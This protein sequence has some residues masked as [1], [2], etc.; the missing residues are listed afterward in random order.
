MNMR[1]Y[2]FMSHMCVGM[3][4]LAGLFLSSCSDDNN[5]DITGGLSIASYAPTKVIAGQEV[6]ITGTGLG[7]VTAV[8]FPG[9]VKATELNKVGSGLIS[10]KVPAG[11]D[12]NGGELS[13]EANGESV[14]A[15]V[16]MTVGAPAVTIVAP[17]DTEVKI[18]E[19]IEI[20]GTDLEFISKAI[21]PGADGNPVEVDAVRFRRKSTSLLYIPVPMG[22]AAGPADVTLV[23]CSGKA[24][25]T[26]GFT[27]SDEISGGE[28]SAEEG[29]VIWDKGFDVT[30]WNWFEPACTDFDFGGYAPKV[31][32]Q[33]KFVISDAKDD[34]RFCY[35]RGSNWGAIDLGGEN[36]PNNI[37]L[38]SAT[39]EVIVTMTEEL[40]QD[41]I[42]GSPVMHLSGTNFTLKKIVLLP[43]V[44]WEGE[45][46][47]QPNWA[48]WIYIYAGNEYNLDFGPVTPEVGDT[49]R[50]V[51]ADHDADITVCI[52]LGWSWWA[53]DV[54]GKGTNTVTVAAGNNE[55]N[56][57]LTADG[58]ANVVDEIILGG[59]DW[60]ALRIEILGK[61]I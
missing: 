9:G 3:A 43:M 6:T 21:F 55:V 19:R 32:Q 51:T 61:K 48:N 42:S 8:V 4:L 33:V 1:K 29:I 54:E 18:N 59:S 37:G 27:L 46:Y 57:V 41:F 36:D 16:P 20:Y 2:R 35:C 24:Y 14:T 13:I 60:T 40:V 22:I 15:R 58:V 49:L 39:T 23:D 31:G 17:L 11:I 25:L 7:D 30:S 34:S 44:L 28:D 56:T 50:I 12:A 52:C 38:T 10:V 45:A 5:E 47:I 53:P 26:S